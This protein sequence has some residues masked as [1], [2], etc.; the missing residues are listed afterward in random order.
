[1]KVFNFQDPTQETYFGTSRGWKVFHYLKKPVRKQ[2]IKHIRILV[3]S[4]ILVPLKISAQFE[5]HS[6]FQ[7]NI[8]RDPIH[9]NGFD[10]SDPVT[11]CNF[12]EKLAQ[13][14]YICLGP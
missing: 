8:F 12:P 9:K 14:K 5:R 7:L 1:M 2:Y 11:I 6:L 4:K 13:S 3:P 10:I